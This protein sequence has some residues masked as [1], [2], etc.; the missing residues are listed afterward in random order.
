MNDA[1]KLNE[2]DREVLRLV[3]NYEPSRASTI[4]EAVHWADRNQDIHYRWQKLEE[5]G[6]IYLEEQ[7]D[8][9]VPINPKVARITQ[10]GH[11]ELAEH[12][13][14]DAPRTV[15][16]RIERLEKQ[17]SKMRETYGEVKQRIVRTEERINEL[18]ADVDGDLEALNSDIENLKRSIDDA[19]LMDASEM[20]FVDD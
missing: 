6:L 15:Q 13:E 12:L 14:E 16:E 20:Q 5:H 10:D 9:T 1:P 19:P 7:R 4:R 2:R 11:N 17:M 3:A 18:E 8:D